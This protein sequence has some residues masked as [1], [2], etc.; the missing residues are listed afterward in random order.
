MEAAAASQT[1]NPLLAAYLKS[2]KPLAVEEPIDVY[3]HRPLAFL[4]ARGLYPTPVSPNLVTFGAMLLGL[5]A[6]VAMV[7]PF[8]HHLQWAGACVFFSAVFD[9]AD[10]QLARLRQSFSAFGRMLDGSADLIGAI[11]AVGGSLWVVWSQNRDQPALAA[12]LVVL[13]ALTTLTSSFHISVYDHYKN[14]FLK[15]T[16]AGGSEGEDYEA[17]VE[18]SRRSRDPRFWIRGAWLLYRFWLKSQRDYIADFDPYTRTRYSELPGFDAH[19]AEIYRRHQAGLM[20][21]WRGLFGYGTVVFGLA[22]SLFFDVLEVYMVVRLVLLNG[23]F[24]GYLRGAQRRA[25]QAVFDELGLS[26]AAGPTPAVSTAN[27]LAGK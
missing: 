4:L 25:S 15:F 3:V 27:A 13:S 9:C 2:L 19:R 22:V 14:L 1:K 11:S 7:V 17:V 23:I 24:Y 16:Y 26:P 18:R 20:R 12:G 10:G 8:E 21:W 6:G 5:F